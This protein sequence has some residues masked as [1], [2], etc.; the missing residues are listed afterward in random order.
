MLA[1]IVEINQVKIL[2]RGVPNKERIAIEFAFDIQLA[3]LCLI[4]GLKNPKN[5]AFTPYNNQLFLFQ[6]EVVSAGT[7]VVVYTGIGERRRTVLQNSGRPALV[8]YWG[9]KHTLFAHQQASI[10]VFL[11]SGMNVPTD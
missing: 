2:D 3:T 8:F 4:F 6:E 7:W 9:L 1:P 10:G 5:G 11:L